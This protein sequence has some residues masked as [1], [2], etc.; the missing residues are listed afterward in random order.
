MSTG[1]RGSTPIE[2]EEAREEARML[3]DLAEV[4]QYFRTKRARYLQE[5][6]E[7]ALATYQPPP[8]SPTPEPGR[9]SSEGDLPTPPTTPSPLH[10]RP[11]RS[12]SQLPLQDNPKPAASFADLHTRKKAP[13]R[14]PARS[15]KRFATHPA[16]FSP[17]AYFYL[18]RAALPEGQSFGAKPATDLAAIN[19]HDKIEGLATSNL[20]GAGKFCSALSKKDL[21]SKKVKRLSPSC[22]TLLNPSNTFYQNLEF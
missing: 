8:N 7:Q 4:N 3:T 11:P 17:P 6:R 15:Y 21:Y 5:A 20:H 9:S 22:L 2:D 16:R 19:H 12:Q 1:I 10:P 13:Q 18:P 14:D